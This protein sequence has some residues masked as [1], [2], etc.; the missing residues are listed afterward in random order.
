MKGHW[1]ACACEILGL[2]SIDDTFNLPVHIMKGTP[3]E[4]LALVHEIAK[5]VVDKLTLV[6]S[7][8]GSMKMGLKS[9]AI[10]SLWLTTDRNP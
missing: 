7:E 5:M 1:L 2:S 10:M 8:D 3:R 4:K 9:Q 6:E